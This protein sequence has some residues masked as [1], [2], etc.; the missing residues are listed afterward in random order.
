MKVINFYGGPGSGKSTKAAGLYYKMNMAGFSVELNNEFA[1][2]C[3]WEDNVPMLKDQLY[4]LAHQHRKIL[5]LV[6]KVDYVITDSPVMLSGI[7]RELYKGPLYSD[8]IDKLA[9]ECYDKYDNINFMLDRPKKVFIQKGRAQN[10]EGSID[11]DQA[12]L[13]M[14]KNE[15]LPFFW[16][17]GLEEDAVDIAYKYVAKKGSNAEWE[18]YLF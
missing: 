2:E 13:E 5:R 14:F 15:K 8:L 9:R 12:I 4:M 10:E 1:K 11:I 17:K 18:K 3:V 16:L 7:Y 6:G